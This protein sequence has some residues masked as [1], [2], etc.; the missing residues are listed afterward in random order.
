MTILFTASR[1]DGFFNIFNDCRIFDGDNYLV[2]MADGSTRAARAEVDEYAYLLDPET[3][4]V[5]EDA[6]WV[7][8]LGSDD[9]I[10]LFI[11]ATADDVERIYAALGNL[12]AEGGDSDGRD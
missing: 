11:S 10:S 9:R 8:P 6:E 12:A 1:K 4:D 3:D 5:I 2:L 7:K